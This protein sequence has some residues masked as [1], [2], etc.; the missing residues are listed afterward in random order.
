[1]GRINQTKL[2]YNCIVKIG[3]L[4]VHNQDYIS[5]RDIA[6]ALDLTYYQVSNI[7]A[8][9]YKHRTNFKYQPRVEINKI[10]HTI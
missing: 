10:S 8:G 6:D 9:R 2:C 3:E 1:M 5:L 4:T 7:S